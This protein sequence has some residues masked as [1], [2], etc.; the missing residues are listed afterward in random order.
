MMEDLDLEDDANWPL[1]N[2]GK[3]IKLPDLPGGK[4]YKRSFI[5]DRVYECLGSER[6]DQVFMILDSTINAA[7]REV[8]PPFPLIAAFHCLIHLLPFA[9]GIHGVPTD[10]HRSCKDIGPSAKTISGTC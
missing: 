1:D 7:K 4:G 10:I 6:N 5:M 2:K 9:F 3:K 8:G